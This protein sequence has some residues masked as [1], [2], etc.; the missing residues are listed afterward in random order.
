M[1]FDD[2]VKWRGFIGVVVFTTIDGEK[3]NYVTQALITLKDEF[4]YSS[5]FLI[6]LVTYTHVLSF[7]SNLIATRNIILCLPTI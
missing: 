2:V 7:N 5:L 4:M 1:L 3:T 6:C